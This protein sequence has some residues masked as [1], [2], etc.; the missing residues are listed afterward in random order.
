MNALAS[1]VE[2]VADLL[3]AFDQVRVDRRYG[4][5]AMTGGI[6]SLHN[7][8]AAVDGMAH[9]AMPAVMNAQFCLPLRSKT[10]A[11]NLESL[12]Q[13]PAVQVVAKR[14]AVLRTDKGSIVAGPLLST[15]PFPVAEVAEGGRV[16]MKGHFAGLPPLA[17]LAANS[18]LRLARI[19]LDIGERNLS[20]LARSQAAACAQP[21]DHAV[22]TSVQGP[23]ALPG[24]VCQD[25][26]DLV[27]LED[28]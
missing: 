16:P 28:F 3:I 21:E 7:T 11:D 1:K 26:C 17:N 15:K 25:P 8:S 6:P 18:D 14:I 13:V 9:E 19:D 20:D 22:H 24:E 5:G 12:P 4:Q 27:R 23:A 2:E 10:L